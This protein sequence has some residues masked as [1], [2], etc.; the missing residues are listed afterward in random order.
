MLRRTE[1]NE[2]KKRRG[3]ETPP[4]EA[5]VLPAGAR[6]RNFDEVLLP[7]SGDMVQREAVRCLHCSSPPCVEACPLRVD[8]PLALR[9]AGEGDLAAAGRVF[10]LGNSLPEICGRVCCQWGHCEGACSQAQEGFPPLAV[11]RIETFLADFARGEMGWAAERPPCSG[12]RVGVVGAG[13]AGL[14]V[15]ELLAGEGHMVTVYDQWPDGG[16]SMR[17][18]L[19]RFKLDHGLVRKRLGLLR[20]LGV[21]FIFNVRIGDELGVDDLLA[22]G[23]EAVFLGTGPGLPEPAG[24][25]GIHLK[26]VYDAIPFLVQANVEQ[27]LRPSALE[28][29]PE[30]GRRVV[31][32]GGGDAAMDCCRTAVRLGAPEVTCYYRRTEGQAPG[33][34][35][36]RRFAREEG[37]VLEWGAAPLRVVG[38][39]A[40]R[41]RAVELVRTETASIDGARGLEVKPLEG[42]RFAVAADTV[43]LALGCRPDP[44]LVEETHGLAADDQGRLTVDPSTGRTSRDRVWAGGGNVTGQDVLARA[45]AQGRAAAGDIHRWLCGRGC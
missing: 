38:D 45:V 14:T 23:F 30:V 27:D 15:A 32:I 8:I 13:P 26:G 31:V 20:S 35:R 42:S 24:I 17:Y 22:Q 44:S 37:V 16:G 25:P 9:R 29:P 6:A 43:V 40:G 34:P 7:W 36:E 12:Y 10:L 28:D 2:M 39:G 41:V 33:N 18:G 3:Q 1:S 11:G 19:P 5:P 4:V 21:E